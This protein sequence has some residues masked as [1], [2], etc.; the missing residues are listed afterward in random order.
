[1]EETDKKERIY[2]IFKEIIEVKK[3]PLAPYVPKKNEF[4]CNLPPSSYG[5]PVGI[6]ECTPEPRT[7][8]YCWRYWCGNC[9]TGLGGMMG[10]CEYEYCMHGR[11]YLLYLNV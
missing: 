10:K 11:K 5:H 9:G 2:R 8:R 3:V 7:C 1:M 4:R 6:E